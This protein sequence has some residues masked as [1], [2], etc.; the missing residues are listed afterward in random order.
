MALS[1]L[2]LK[3]SYRYLSNDL[4]PNCGNRLSTLRLKRSYRYR[5]AQS[6]HAHPFVLSTLRFKRSY[7]YT[8]AKVSD[9]IHRN[10]FNAAS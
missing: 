4:S 8:V 2:R 5:L 9:V 10:A 6:V 7:R 3:R 1:T